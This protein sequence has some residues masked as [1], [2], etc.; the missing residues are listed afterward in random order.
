[1][2]KRDLPAYA[3][4][5]LGHYVY[6]LQN[7][8]DRK[9]FY[10]GKGQ[11]N[12]VV[13]HANLTLGPG[14]IP[15]TMKFQ[16]IQ[17]I[18]AAGEEVKCLIVQHGLQDD[19]HAS[20]TE[21][22]VYGIL[23]YLEEQAGHDLSSLTNLIHPPTYSD[24]GLS[25]LEDVIAIYGEPADGSLLPHNSLFIKPADLW[26]KGMSRE[27]LWE[28][29]HGWWPLNANRLKSIRYV[30]AIPNFVIRA[31]WE[32]RSEDWRQQEPGDR[33]WENVL[34]KRERGEEKRPRRGFTSCVDISDTKFAALINKSVA[35]TFLEGQGKRPNVTYM[36]DWR[37]KDLEKAKQPRPPFWNVNYRE[38][39]RLQ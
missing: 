10:V 17:E 32:V 4:E 20:S 25:P 6:A 39:T 1:M 24:F 37:V 8:L 7:P 9:I 18:H 30:F 14:E 29:T 23:K 19:D 12:R 28:V 13:S 34:E 2:K 15:E 16:T 21:S 11:G 26:T 3:Q 36:D 35:H 22:A 31:A 33:G 5:Q 38:S 27:E